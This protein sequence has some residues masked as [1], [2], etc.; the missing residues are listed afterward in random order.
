MDQEGRTIVTTTEIRDAR[1]RRK[2]SLAM[3]RAAKRPFEK[4]FLSARLSGEHLARLVEI[5]EKFIDEA[6]ETQRP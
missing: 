5:L 3:A 6:T 2:L 1:W 4:E